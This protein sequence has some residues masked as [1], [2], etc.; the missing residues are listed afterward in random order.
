[1]NKL[2]TVD[3]K[4]T[5]VIY[6]GNIIN[7][8]TVLV[9]DYEPYR[10]KSEEKNK[11]LRQIKKEQAN[12]R[13]LVYEKVLSLVLCIFVFGIAS[14]YRYCSVYKAQMQLTEVN[15]KIS[16]IQKENDDLR[17]KMVKYNNMQYIEETATSKLHMVR[18]DKNSVI[19]A[20]LTNNYFQDSKQ[21]KTSLQNYSFFEK[22]LN[23][24][25]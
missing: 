19:Y 4:E 3:D 2:L 15:S 6:N 12:K 22:I 10:K 25:K 20:N 13:K 18:A 8:N 17:L 23:F 1:M 11:K 24:I 7:G 14:I 16:S 5:K 21:K 9:P